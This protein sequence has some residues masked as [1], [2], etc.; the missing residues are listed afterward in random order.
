MS[1]L[2]ISKQYGCRPSEVFPEMDEYTAYCFDEA[3]TYIILK[4]QEDEENKPHFKQKDDEKPVQK[5]RNAADLYKSMGY[6]RNQFKK[7][8]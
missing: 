1:V 7:T 6:G 3:C 4:L 5:F 8:K 2:A